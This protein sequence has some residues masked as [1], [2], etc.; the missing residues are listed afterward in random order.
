M[1]T[2]SAKNGKLEF[3][4][5][6]KPAL[7]VFIDVVGKFTHNMFVIPAGTTSCALDLGPGTWKTRVGFMI[8]EPMTGTFTWSP[9]AD[10]VL[11]TTTSKSLR[12]LPCEFT[13]SKMLQIENGLRLFTSLP[14]YTYC[15]VEMWNVN[16]SRDTASWYYY[17]T[18]T[19]SYVDVKHMDYKEQ[20]N[21]RIYN[22]KSIPHETV[23]RCSE[24]YSIERRTAVTPNRYVDA[25]EQASR[26][27]G[28]AIINHPRAKFTSHSE[29]LRYQAALAKS[30]MK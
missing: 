14:N 15:I 21:L 3:S 6:D 7:A 12:K 1:F 20:Y 10:P 28:Q 8:G 17:Y 26:L 16:E 25:S 18:H 30:N 2:V 27:A 5:E 9:F 23:S 11:L 19:K 29:Y 4:I 22:L 13:I 24:G